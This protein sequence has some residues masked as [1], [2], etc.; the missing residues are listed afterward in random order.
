MLDEQID[1]MVEFLPARHPELTRGV[2]AEVPDAVRPSGHTSKLTHAAKLDPLRAS[3]NVSSASASSMPMV[4]MAGG[5]LPE[6][7][8]QSGDTSGSLRI[9]LSGQ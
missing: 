5:M 7:S 2:H 1:L 9:S 4:N 3:R 8:K 6:V